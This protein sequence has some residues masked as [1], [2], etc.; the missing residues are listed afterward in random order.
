MPKVARA[1]K[2]TKKTTGKVLFD[3]D[4][5][6][7]MVRSFLV[8]LNRPNDV[9]ESSFMEDCAAVTSIKNSYLKG[10]LL[11]ACG[12]FEKG[13]NTARLHMQ[14]YVV[15]THPHRLVWAINRYTGNVKPR[16]ERFGSDAEMRKYCLDPDKD[17]FIKAGFELGD[18]DAAL[19]YFRELEN[20]G[21]APKAPKP[22]AVGQLYKMIENEEITTV[23]QLKDQFPHQYFQRPRELTLELDRAVAKRQL[24][25]YHNN[26][27]DQYRPR[28][29]Q[30]WL[31]TYLR[32]APREDR[33]VIFICDS[34]GCSGKSRFIQEMLR[35]STDDEFSVVNLCPAPLRDMAD[36]YPTRGCNVLFID[37]TRSKQSY[38]SHVYD[39]AENL[40]SGTIFSQKYDA[41]SKLFAPPHVVVMTNDPK[42]DFGDETWFGED[43][44]QSDA[45]NHYI[46]TGTPLVRTYVDGGIRNHKSCERKAPFT[47]D[48]YMWWDLTE[49]SAYNEPF[50]R[51][52]HMF[53]PPFKHVD[54]EFRMFE[55][56]P[57]CM[58]N[59]HWDFAED[60]SDIESFDV[61]SIED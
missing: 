21:E 7:P 38:S 42:P 37:I 49:F 55:K 22:T 32:E 48:R 28:M 5:K 25:D 29:W 36:A 52:E 11:Y 3:D 17:T 2:S 34:A 9:T 58:R 20:E 54:K 23:S 10:E 33:N 59:Y 24:M 15:P 60:A 18:W 12:Q 50:N 53:F 31:S 61:S 35:S 26:R 8:T 44:I 6:Q 19:N 13:G 45:R 57:Y 41:F 39:F 47:H 56:V 43:Y 27:R 16:D 40:K 14:A 30:H 46:Q 4:E 1:K 51:E